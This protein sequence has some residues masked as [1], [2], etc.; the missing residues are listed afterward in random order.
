MQE[1][2]VSCEAPEVADARANREV[3]VDTIHID[4]NREILAVY[5]LSITEAAEQ[6]SAAFNGMQVGEI[7]RNLDF[8]QTGSGRNAGRVPWKERG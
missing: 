6:V 1:K 3:L 5:G 4:Y 8:T 7:I 2:R